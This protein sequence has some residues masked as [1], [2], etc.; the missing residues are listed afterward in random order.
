MRAASVWMNAALCAALVFALSIA[1]AQAAHH[2][3]KVPSY[4]TAAV[5][6]PGRP[7]ADK[8]RDALRK[9]AE[10]L[11][12]S[13]VKPGDKVAEIWPGGGYYTRMLSKVVGPSGHVYMVVPTPASLGRPMGGMGQMGGP[14]RGGPGNGGPGNGGPGMAGKGMGGPG[15]GRPPMRR[16]DMMAMAN[17][18]AQNPEYSNVSVVQMEAGP[19]FRLPEQVDL[20]WTTDNY[21]DLHNIPNGDISIFDKRVFDSLKDGGIYFVEDHAA[22]AGAGTSQTRT[23]H[24]IDPAAVKMEAEAVGFEFVGESRVLHSFKDTH[25]TPIFDKTIRGHTDRFIFKFRKPQ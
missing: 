17:A 21:H 12:F 7:E 15:G 16:P 5:D 19:A 18:I 9:P 20:I 14:G 23:L 8:M 11:A 6:D 1:G 10:V 2:G 13:G 25:K 3:H 24:R 4:I 22:A